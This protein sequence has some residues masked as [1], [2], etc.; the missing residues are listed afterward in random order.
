MPHAELLSVLHAELY[1]NLMPSLHPSL[2]NAQHITIYREGETRETRK[3]GRGFC[4][5]KEQPNS[6]SKFSSS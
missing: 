4:V 5:D 1:P 6:C 3:V 2:K